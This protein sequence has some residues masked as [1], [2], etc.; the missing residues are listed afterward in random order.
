MLFG[1]NLLIA[2]LRSK[3]ERERVS[4]SPAMINAP[5][6]CLKC[7]LEIPADAP[8][9]GCPS[10]LLE[11]G[12]GLLP[13]ALVAAR[14]AST[15]IS[16]K[17]DQGGSAENFGAN[18]AAAL[19]RVKKQRALPRHWGN[20]ATTNYWKWSVGAVRGWYFA[21]GKRV[22]IAQWHSR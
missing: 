19:A 8:E 18:A 20:S 6:L 12:L 15:V 10:C 5:R 3:K 4:D 7:G 17:A 14:D 13:N 16:T 2:F 22:S 1:H 21:P 9:G 11:N